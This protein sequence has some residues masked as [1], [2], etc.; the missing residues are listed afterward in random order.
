MTSFRLPA[1]KSRGIQSVPGR[2]ELGNTTRLSSILRNRRAG[3][4]LSFIGKVIYLIGLGGSHDRSTHELPRLSKHT[5]ARLD[6]RE[7]LSRMA[8]A[9]SCRSGHSK[10]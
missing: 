8:K 4:G 6:S 7:T 9:F 5:K 1:A 3:L 10:A 2:L